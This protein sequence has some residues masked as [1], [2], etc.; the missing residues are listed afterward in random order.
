LLDAL[1]AA[2]ARLRRPRETA[3]PSARRF[4]ELGA[5]FEGHL[6]QLL[7]FWARARDAEAGGFFTDL[8]R[9]GRP[10]GPQQRALVHAARLVWAFSAAH[11]RGLGGGRY[12]ELADAGAEA[13][14]RYF[15]DPLHGGWFW[16]VERFGPVVSPEKDVYGQAFGIYAS[17]EHALASG[18]RR[19]AA[20]ATQTAALLRERA[21]HPSGL[22]FFER[23]SRDWN[24]RPARARE[25]NSHLHLLE[26]TATLLEL[27][28]A[29]ADRELL[30]ELRD[31][32]VS[33]MLDRAR[34][35]FIQRFDEALAPLV[36]RAPR[37]TSY[38]H[39]IEGAWLLLHAAEALGEPPAQTLP[40]SLALGRRTLSTGCDARRGGIYDAGPLDGPA[41][42]RVR[43]WWAQAEGLVGFL[44]LFQASGERPF[45]DAFER[46]GDWILTRQ[47][48]RRGGEWFAAV[49]ERGRVLDG[50]KSHGWKS[51]YHG[52]RALLEVVRILRELEGAA[53]ARARPASPSSGAPQAL[54]R[55]DRP[56]L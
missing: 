28:G 34:G 13:L 26:A 52:V 20:R 30:R 21:R 4:A 38:G 10:R 50:R 24:P 44:R 35:C 45:W 31:L 54:L 17:S 19:S 9:A 48:D 11:R 37:D 25:L 2:L 18:D 49:S 39:D 53:P 27:T 7:A 15:F 12:L 29:A 40:V 51:A 1:R 41:S 55:S 43:I 8:D 14:D 23:L 6:E 3:P 32:I 46:V 22:G 36:E 56:V 33:R 42:S 47:A 5:R 16:S